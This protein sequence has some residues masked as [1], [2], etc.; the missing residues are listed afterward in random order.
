MTALKE[1]LIQLSAELGFVKVGFASAEPLNEEYNRFENWLGEGM[2]ADMHWL[3][4]NK[5]KRQNPQLILE[6]AKTVIITAY[7]YY[8]P[9]KHEDNNSSRGKISRYAWGD[10]YHDII[11]PKLRQLAREIA[12][13][14]LSAESKCYVDTGPIL[15][16]QWAERAGIGW[17]G[18]NGNILTKDY[19][20]WILL[21]S[22]I[23]NVEFEPDKPM[24]NYC[25]K[26]T[27]CLDACPTG[28]I[29]QPKV[30]DARKCLSY[31]TIEAKPDKEIPP[32]IAQNARGWLYGCDICQDICP[33][34]RKPVNS[35]ET[36]F[37]PRK[38]ETGLDLL[39]II[40]FTKEEYL[41][42]FRRSPMKRAKHEGLK[43]NIRDIFSLENDVET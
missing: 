30:I 43:R 18:K 7:N 20:S 19:G 29:I 1:R 33:W 12:Q 21:G 34:N 24:E 23:T 35:Q 36:A 2:N 4:R 15:E 31:W 13:S 41:E 42:R 40:N 6:N 8:T 26:C 22:I 37:L 3:E 9:F 11:L 16:R 28:A 5:E 14:A 32:E 39:Q 25:G 27:K 17:Q 10:D 38:E